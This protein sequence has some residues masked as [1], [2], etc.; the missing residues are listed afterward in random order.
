M[1]EENVFDR[2]NNWIRGIESSVVNMVSSVVPWL[3][4]L[5]PA[6]MSY[7]HMVTSLEFPN[8]IAITT[9]GLVE[10]LGF[11]TISTSVDF[12]NHNRKYSADKNRV[13]LFVPVLSFFFYL[14]VILTMN[15][16]LEWN[17]TRPVIVLSKAF[18]TLLTIPGGVTLAVR[19]MHQ[20][21][22][23]SVSVAKVKR[24]LGIG[25]KGGKL[26]QNTENVPDPRDWRNVAHEDR[27]K[28]A[29]MSPMQISKEYGVT[30]RTARNWLPKAKLHAENYVYSQ[31]NK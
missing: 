24:K 26:P 7:T 19:N 25:G 18:L 17:P 28:V 15:V 2:I 3:A 1:R 6:Y 10:G 20:N 5:P 29:A 23:Y 27:M 4:P 14:G 13:P 11:A 16:L 8:W 9:A 30:P 31:R 22:E 12:W 21:V